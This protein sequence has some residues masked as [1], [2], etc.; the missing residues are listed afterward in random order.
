MLGQ[1]WVRLLAATVLVLSLA[2][3]LSAYFANRAVGEQFISYV[4]EGTLQRN[5]RL[6]RILGPMYHDVGRGNVQFF[7][8]RMAEA[9]NVR[10]IVA[11]STG[12]VVADS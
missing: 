9:S 3:G 12:T 6:Q 10:L 7:V 5:Y 1:L 11:D 8:Q 2:V 4:D